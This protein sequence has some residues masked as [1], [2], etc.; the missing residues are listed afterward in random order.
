MYAAG[1]KMHGNGIIAQGV[2]LNGEGAIFCFLKG[3]GQRKDRKMG[4]RECVL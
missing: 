1:Y 2:V 3:A 4:M